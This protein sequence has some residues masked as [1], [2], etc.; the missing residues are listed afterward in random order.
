MNDQ[1]WRYYVMSVSELAKES[2]RESDMSNTNTDRT[3]IIED[4]VAILPNLPDDVLND[5]HK[6]AGKNVGL[7]RF[8]AEDQADG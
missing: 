2:E 4:I 8:F 6:L 7:M 5:I 1:Q 3:K